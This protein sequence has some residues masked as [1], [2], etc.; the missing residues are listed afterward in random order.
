M[1]STIDIEFPG[2]HGLT[3][4]ARLD[5]PQGTPTAYAVFAHCFTCSKDSKATFR[6]LARARLPAAP[7]TFVDLAVDLHFG[8]LS[9]R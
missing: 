5:M 9:G 3:L 1:K 6:R 2:S 7:P 8:I 4:A